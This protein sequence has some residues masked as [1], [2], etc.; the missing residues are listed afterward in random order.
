LL[1]CSNRNDILVPW[2]QIIL[3]NLYLHWF[4]NG[5][6]FASK[7]AFFRLFCPSPWLLNSLLFSEISIHSMSNSLFILFKYSI[8][9]W[10]KIRVLISQAS[11]LYNSKLFSEHL[12]TH[13]T[14]ELWPQP[15]YKVNQNFNGG[16]WKRNNSM[17]KLHLS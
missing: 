17:W 10:G 5:I 13:C 14:L 12:G 11:I 8:N 2:M 6:L 7:W 15:M 16:Q 3:S 1:P 4:M 9:Q